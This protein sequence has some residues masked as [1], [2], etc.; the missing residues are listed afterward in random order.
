MY[1]CLEF[2]SQYICESHKGLTPALFVMRK[3]EALNIQFYVGFKLIL[4][5][6]MGTC[7]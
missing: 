7:L 3:P 1:V 4:Q 2:L 6:E 5:G